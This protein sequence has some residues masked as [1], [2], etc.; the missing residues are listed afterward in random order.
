M[1]LKFL[2]CLLFCSQLS[3][4]YQ[5]KDLKTKITDPTICTFY[6]GILV[7]LYGLYKIDDAGNNF[8]SQWDGNMGIKLEEFE[9]KED[10]MRIEQKNIQIK[11]GLTFC[12]FGLSSIALSYY[13]K[14][15]K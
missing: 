12:F 4:T 3:L 6:G 8:D 5:L 7:T 2:L 11:K 10:Q 13:L 9:K 1:K 15:L 14:S